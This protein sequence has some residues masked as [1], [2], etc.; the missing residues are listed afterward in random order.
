M[1]K[2]IFVGFKFYRRHFGGVSGHKNRSTLLIFGVFEKYVR[3]G[4][5]VSHNS[6]VDGGFFSRR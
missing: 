6:Q 2:E 1:K 3:N 5:L 4:N